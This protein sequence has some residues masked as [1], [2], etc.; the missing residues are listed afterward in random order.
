MESVLILYAT[1]E[2]HA[3][4]IA[5]HIA[6]D[7]GSRGLTAELADARGLPREFS[8]DHFTTAIVIG[9]VHVG[10]H[11]KELVEFVKRHVRDL[12][13]IGSAFIS[14][15]LSQAGVE[16]PQASPERRAQCAADAQRMIDRFLAETG[17]LP[18]KT[19]PVA[20]ALMYSKYSFLVRFV[21]K[22]IAARAGAS[23][24]ASRDHIF[25]DWAAL[26]RFVGELV[27][28]RALTSQSNRR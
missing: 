25:T 9:S 13:T 10:E 27:D 16:D 28:S 17:W 8:L 20:G 22:R 21:M 7:L 15:S 3:R 5:E 18:S 24:D 11:E 19:K 4:R 2:G 6:D 14:V 26:D 23:T 12:E 1:R